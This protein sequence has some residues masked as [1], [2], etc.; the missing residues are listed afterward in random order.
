LKIAT[1]L[2]S[3]RKIIYSLYSLKRGCI[4]EDP[5]GGEDAEAVK[6]GVIRIG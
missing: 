6:E 5:E 1:V 3:I 4:S 2:H